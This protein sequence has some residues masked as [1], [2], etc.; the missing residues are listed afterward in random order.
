MISWGLES[1]FDM[2][3]KKRLFFNTFR[4]LSNCFA[5]GKNRILKRCIQDIK[6]FN[7]KFENQ[8]KAILKMSRIS[9]IRYKKHF[10]FEYQNRNK[11]RNQ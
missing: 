4:K 3:E 1:I 7:L 9:E 2:N 5:K 11:L 8:V 10:I 6:N